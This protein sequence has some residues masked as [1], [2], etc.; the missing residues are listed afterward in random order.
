MLLLIASARKASSRDRDS[1][2]VQGQVLKGKGAGKGKMLQTSRY[3]VLISAVAHNHPTAILG[4][5]AML[6]RVANKYANVAR[7]REVGSN[8]VINKYPLVHCGV[9]NIV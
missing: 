9:W 1:W 3:E 4:G 7:S 8:A 2:V 6:T 5:A